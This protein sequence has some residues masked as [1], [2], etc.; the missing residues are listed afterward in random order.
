MTPVPT[1]FIGTWAR[2]GNCAM[3]EQRVAITAEVASVG[4]EEPV[5]VVYYADDDTTG[6]KP[7]PGD[8]G[9]GAL[10]LAEEGNADNFVYDAEHDVLIHNTQGYNIPGGA[11]LLK[12]CKHS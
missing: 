3:P 1:A 5:P 4:T 12:R 10:L 9:H 8:D 2:E 6:H 11:E 7:F